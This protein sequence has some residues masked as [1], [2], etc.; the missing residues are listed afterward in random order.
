MLHLWSL[1]NDFDARTAS[2]QDA[3]AMKTTLGSFDLDF[4]YGLTDQLTVALEENILIRN[5]SET[6][7]ARQTDSSK[8]NYEGVGDP[9]FGIIYRYV[10]QP[11]AGITGDVKLTVAPPLIESKAPQGTGSGTNGRGGTLATFG[12]RLY[13][14]KDEQELSPGLN[15]TYI[16]KRTIKGN[17]DTT[18]D[19]VFVANFDFAYR[20]HAT[21]VF[22][23]QPNIGFVTAYDEVTR[24]ASSNPTTFKIQHPFH[25]EL[26]LLAGFKIMPKVVAGLSVRGTKYTADGNVTTTAGTTPGQADIS[27][28]LV[29]LGVGIEL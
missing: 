24:T 10:E 28:F 3:F 7:I 2:G 26:G 16:S 1:V 23:L 11:K 29:D 27:L 14:K 18:T 6:T 5:Q 21:P 12:T 4:N 17:P 25:A 20:Y 15:F 22:F 13:W 19:G 8:T 9:E